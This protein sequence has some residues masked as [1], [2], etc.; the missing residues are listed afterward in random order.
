MVL[1]I[2]EYS[3]QSVESIYVFNLIFAFKNG[4]TVAIMT[5]KLNVR[6]VKKF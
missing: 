6:L 2:N 3:T 4:Q 1:D 5:I